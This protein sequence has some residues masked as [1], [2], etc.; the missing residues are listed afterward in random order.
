MSILYEDATEF[1]ALKYKVHFN[2]FSLSF[3]SIAGRD[4]MAGLDEY[5]WLRLLEFWIHLL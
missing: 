3:P 4:N 2:I 5:Q 1:M